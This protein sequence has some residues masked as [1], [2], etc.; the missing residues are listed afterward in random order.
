MTFSGLTTHPSYPQRININDPN[1]DENC[2]YFEKKRFPKPDYEDLEN[3]SEEELK[4]NRYIWTW[5]NDNLKLITL[6]ESDIKFKNGKPITPIRTGIKG[7]GILPKFGPQHA[8]DPVVTCYINNKLNFLAVL[9]SDVN[10]YAIP[11]G[12]IDPGE[13]YPATLKRE[14]EEESCQGTNPAI[15]DKVFEN[16]DII[17]AGPTFDD[18]RTTD[19]IET[20]TW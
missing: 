17:Y 12:F 15:L 13:K 16:G 2:P 19:N 5:F 7:R 4:N 10:E 11:G 8:A 14:F 6:N 1:Y 18:P 20:S 9:R 3:I